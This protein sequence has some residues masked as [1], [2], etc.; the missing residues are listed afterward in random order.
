MKRQ[1]NLMRDV[2]LLAARVALGTSIAAHGAQKMFGWFGGPGREGAAKMFESLGFRP[3]DRQVTLAAGT[4]IASG[5]LI[6][7]GTG[8]PIGPALLASVMTTAAG[9]V[10]LKNGFFAAKQGYELNAMY[11][12][13]ALLLAMEDHGRLSVDQLIGLR[14]REIPAWM[15]FAAYA[16]GI[17]GGLYMLSRREVQQPPQQRPSQNGAAGERQTVPA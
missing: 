14:K 12:A 11:A 5:V 15:R 1:D 2:A 6:A 13:G 8:G 17:A 3:G 4:E 9:S 16:G 7:T 10:H